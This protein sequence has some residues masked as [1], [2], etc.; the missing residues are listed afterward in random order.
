MTAKGHAP[1]RI[2]LIGAGEVAEH[3]HLK[4]LQ[5]VEGAAV[6]SIAD[7]DAARRAHVAARYG[8]PFQAA[9]VE[10]VLDRADIV[11]V[12]TPPGTHREIAVA[13]LRAGRHVL[14]EKP[15]AL[16]MDDCDALVDAADLAHGLAMTGFHMRWHRLLRQAR[17]RIRS[18]ALGRLESIRTSWNSPRGDDIA[19]PWKRTRVTGG[20]A[21][22]ELGVHLVDLW[23]F[24]LDT[25][26]EEVFARA[27]HGTRDD[28]SATMSAQLA[29]GMLAEATISE[30][31]SHDIEVEVCGDAGRLRVSCQRFDGLEEYARR[32]TAGMMGPRV[33]G[34]QRTL[35]ELPRGLARMRKL[36]DYGDSYR[37]E[38]Q[39]LVDLARSGRAPECTMEDGRRATQV[40]LAAAASAT[41]GRPVRVADAP[42]DLAAAR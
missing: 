1:L 21:L 16:T 2:A 8:I 27:R 10:D 30:R 19:P 22:V 33:R 25:E 14:V 31:T 3:K 17:E 9:G 38:W 42:R 37:G 29:N 15:L 40:V 26:V 7:P 24:L 35:R 12:L 18:G 4:A 11:G 6:D 41:S 23:R 39:H 36:G 13:A 5:E 34:I 28:E 32:E 20:G